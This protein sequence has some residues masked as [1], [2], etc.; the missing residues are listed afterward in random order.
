MEFDGIAGTGTPAYMAPE[1]IMN[2]YTESSDMW[3]LGVTI[4]VMV[5]GAFPFDYDDDVVRQ[6]VTVL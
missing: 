3:S 5:S 2:D 4:F 1:L 6:K